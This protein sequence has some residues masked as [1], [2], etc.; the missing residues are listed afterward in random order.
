ALK[1]GGSWTETAEGGGV[2]TT[3]YTAETAGTNLKA[4][5][6][7]GGWT[8]GASSGEY[9]ITSGEPTNFDLKWI[10]QNDLVVSDYVDVNR[11]NGIV[12][13]DYHN[14]VAGAEINVTLTDNVQAGFG[15][16]QIGNFMTDDG[17]GIEILIR[18]NKSGKVNIKAKLNSSS[19]G[20]ISQSLDVFFSP[21][22]MNVEIMVN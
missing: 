5:L 8:G 10:N 17:G 12:T 19:L 13:D 22:D 21:K 15:E 16:G 7:L 9:A 20:S 14:P 6:T 4:V 18:S 3:T 2:Y 11:V 1:T